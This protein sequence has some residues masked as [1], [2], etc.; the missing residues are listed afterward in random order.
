MKL[1]SVVLLQT[2]TAATWQ[3]ATLFL[4]THCAL[5]WFQPL[6]PGR[7]HRNKC[8]WCVLL[9]N[10]AIVLWGVQTAS[11]YVLPVNK[12]P[13]YLTFNLKGMK[14]PTLTIYSHAFTKISDLNRKYGQKDR[15]WNSLGCFLAS[16]SDFLVDTESW[17]LSL[18]LSHLH[19]SREWGQQQPRAK[20]YFGQLWNISCLLTICLLSPLPS[21][22]LQLESAKASTAR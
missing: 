18:V 9:W 3:S 20:N 22:Q 6:H 21:R 12:K 19:P 13:W 15:N 17:S 8:E 1:P 11:L 16:G 10:N 7:L 14:A 4:S 5:C 2:W